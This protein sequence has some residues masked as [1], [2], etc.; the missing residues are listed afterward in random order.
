MAGR[1]PGHAGDG[2]GA[3]PQ[4]GGGVGVGSTGAGSE[5]LVG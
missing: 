1:R 3:R 2:A 4:R 5:G